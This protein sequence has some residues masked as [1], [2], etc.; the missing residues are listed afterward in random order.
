MP[1]Y[2]VCVC[3]VPTKPN[4]ANQRRGSPRTLDLPCSAPVVN[5][6]CA[7]IRLRVRTSCPHN[8]CRRT[9]RRYVH[10]PHSCLH[11]LGSLFQC[12]S[13]R[14]CF[15]PDTTSYAVSASGNPCIHN[16]NRPHSSIHEGDS[17]SVCSG[18]F[19]SRGRATASHTANTCSHSRS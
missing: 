2:T 6:T 14:I 4:K 15:R 5:R 1:N 7:Q 11:R 10:T 19:P 13:P 16:E 3:F 9:P 17:H 8:P 12:R 18:N